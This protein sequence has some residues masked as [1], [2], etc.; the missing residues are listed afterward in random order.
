MT[1]PAPGRSTPDR[2]DTRLALILAIVAAILLFACLAG[3]AAVVLWGRSMADRP[4]SGQ[5]V[6]LHQ[7]ARDGNL[8]FRVSQVRCGLREIGDELVRQVALGQFCL[9]DVAVRNVGDRPA[10]FSDGLQRAYGPTGK[11]Y[12]ADSGAGILA[13]PRQQVFLNE[14]NPGNEVVGVVVYDIPVGARITRIELR[15]RQDSA[16]VVVRTG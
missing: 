7:P 3:V 5:T 8:E 15:E 12:G 1:D 11:Q 4:R 10:T 9:V 16:G 6:G 13:N 2:A 14:L